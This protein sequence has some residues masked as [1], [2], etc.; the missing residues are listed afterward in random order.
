[1][2]NNLPTNDSLQ[3]V[4]DNMPELTKKEIDEYIAINQKNF[5]KIRLSL[6]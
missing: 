5:D 2:E 4:I 6:V 1:L 3:E